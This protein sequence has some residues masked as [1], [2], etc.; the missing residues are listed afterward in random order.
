MTTELRIGLIGFGWMGQAHSRSYRN[1]PVYFP[2]AGIR[3]RL[4]AVADTVPARL[5]LARNNFGYEYATVDWRVVIERSDIDVV[6]VT[7]P[8]ALHQEL[9]TAAAAAG[10]HVF[11]EK[12]VGI[13][14]AAT[15]PIEPAARQAAAIAP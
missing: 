7:A 13:T 4:V 11:C 5:E 10:K 6:D 15:A 9:A 2:E 12:P 8:N 1:I 3:P 14:P